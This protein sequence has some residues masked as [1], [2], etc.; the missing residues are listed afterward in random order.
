M[1]AMWLSGHIEH[2][3]HSIE[4][5]NSIPFTCPCASI[6][7]VVM[8]SVDIAALHPSV[9]PPT[10]LKRVCTGT[11]PS[12]VCNSPQTEHPVCTTLG[13][14]SSSS[15]RKGSREISKK[16]PKKAEGRDNTEERGSE[17]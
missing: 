2:K 14:S 13:H 10:D 15:K 5:T 16:A 17:S 9:P 8:L 6:C 7:Q 3:P 1:L 4:A 12:A 11:T